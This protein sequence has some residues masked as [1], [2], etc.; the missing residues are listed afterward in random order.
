MGAWNLKFG[1]YT[2]DNSTI[3]TL[4]AFSAAGKKT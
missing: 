3:A 2:R 1:F 4:G